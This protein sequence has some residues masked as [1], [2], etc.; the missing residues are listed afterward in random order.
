VG[1]A[2]GDAVV[3]GARVGGDVGDVVGAAD[4]TGENLTTRIF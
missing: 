1:V 4:G 2:L 3:T